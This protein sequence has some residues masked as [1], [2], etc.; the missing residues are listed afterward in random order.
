MCLFFAKFSDFGKQRLKQ[1][2]ISLVDQ[3][4]M[5]LSKQTEK[6]RRRTTEGQIR[7]GVRNKSPWMSLRCVVDT[8]NIVVRKCGNE[9]ES[10]EGLL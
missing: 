9:Q 8:H 10:M 7:Q 5:F 4:T 6:Q 3:S 2:D 1:T